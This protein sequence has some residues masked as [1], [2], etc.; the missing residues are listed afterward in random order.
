MRAIVWTVVGLLLVAAIAI[1]VYMKG[2]D[3]KVRQ[4][5]LPTAAEVKQ[6]ADRYLKK[7]D[8]Y[9]AEAAKLRQTLGVQ[10]TGEKKAALA[11]LDSTVVR[12]KA[13]AARLAQAKADQ[14]E[15]VKKS[16]TA[17]QKDYSDLKHELDKGLSR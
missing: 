7:A 16:L 9:A 4:A 6:E 13:E 12:I 3:A 1:F 15:T 5:G 11:K 10:A 17:L 8:E 2:Q 14:W